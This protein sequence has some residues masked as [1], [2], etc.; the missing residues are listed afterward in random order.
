[1][2]QF[3]VWK[4]E[5]LGKLLSIASFIKNRGGNTNILEEKFVF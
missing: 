2:L 4:S 3:P 1:M 5:D